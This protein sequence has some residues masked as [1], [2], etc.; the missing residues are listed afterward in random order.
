MF[1]I[2]DHIYSFSDSNTNYR[3]CIT[4]AFNVFQARKKAEFFLLLQ[5][6]SEVNT[7]TKTKEP[8]LNPVSSKHAFFWHPITPEMEIAWSE[9]SG[10]QK[11]L[12]DSKNEWS[13]QEWTVCWRWEQRKWEKLGLAVEGTEM[14]QN[15]ED[16]LKNNLARSHHWKISLGKSIS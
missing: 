12:F 7:G 10:H 8:L 4:I 9:H 15:S 11:W 14:S 13:R 5:A 16:R 1:S 6:K 3:W 2:T